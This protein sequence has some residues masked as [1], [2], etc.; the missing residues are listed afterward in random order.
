MRRM[1]E[2]HAAERRRGGYRRDSVCLA[3]L[4][5]DCGGWIEN[6]EIYYSEMHLVYFIEEIVA[7]PPS[8]GIAL[9]YPKAL[10]DHRPHRLRI[11]LMRDK[12]RVFRLELSQLVDVQGRPWL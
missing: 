11:L 7:I 4:A 8:Q 12:L 2:E 10:C 3:N 5:L 9:P 6:L 1:N